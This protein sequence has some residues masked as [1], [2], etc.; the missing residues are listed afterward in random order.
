MKR[1]QVV[2]DSEA[3]TESQV[4]EVIED[5]GFEASPL[6]DTA[7]K[8]Q[9]QSARFQVLGM[10]CSACSSAVERA[11]LGIRGV[12][13]A[14]VSLSLEQAEVEFDASLTSTV[15]PCQTACLPPSDFFSEPTRQPSW[16]RILWKFARF[17]A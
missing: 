5:A 4:L 10:H 15:R 1:G 9:L 8:A 7:G 14:T 17:L 13:S 2:Y 16:R 11:L 12:A 3:L 6:R